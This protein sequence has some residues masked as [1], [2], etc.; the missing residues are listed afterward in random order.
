[1][2]KTV[3]VTFVVLFI[4]MPF[5]SFA[6]TKIG[7][8]SIDEVFGMMPETKKADSSLAEYQK[9]LQESY[10]EQETALNNALDKFFKDSVTMSPAVKEAKRKTLQNDVVGLQN[11]QSQ[12]NN[13][14][15]TEKEKL[16]KPIREKMLATIKEVAQAM[17]YE[18]VLYKESAIVFP[19]A[20]DITNAVKNKLGIK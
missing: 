3:L 2:K 9:A 10:A 11:K 6:Q 1:M 17:G 7:Y 13:Q 8:V 4:S 5:A 18:H 20:A 12:L 14:L 16:V 19:A 15:E